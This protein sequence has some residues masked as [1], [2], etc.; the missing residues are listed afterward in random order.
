MKHIYKLI[1]VV[2]MLITSVASAQVITIKE[3]RT[4]AIGTNVT[5]RGIIING[6]EIGGSR[7]ITDGTA[8]LGI[9]ASAYPNLKRG[10]SIE[11]MGDLQHFSNLLQISANV[12]ITVLDSN[13][14]VPAPIDFTVSSAA[15][16]EQYEGQLVKINNVSSFQVIS[17]NTCGSA[18]STFDGN[19][20]YCLSNNSATPMRVSNPTGSAGDIIGKS[21]P[22]GKVSVV[23]I[24]SQF[25]AGAY[26]TTAT[27][28][29]Q[30][31]VRLY[32]DFILPPKPNIIS[33]PRPAMN[34]KINKPEITT[35]SIKVIF[36]TQNTG[37][38]KIEYG[39]TSALGSALGDSIFTTD[40]QVE[41]ANLTP[42]TIY[43]IKAV[44]A[45][46]FGVSSSKI[47][48]MVT[49]SLSSGV[50][51]VYFNNPVDTTAMAINK[52]I[53]LDKTM[54]D[55]VVA[56]INKAKKTLD[57]AIYN[58]NPSGSADFIAALNNAYSRG[59][60]VRIVYDGS[61]ANVG[62]NN[63]DPNIGII[64]RPSG[65]G[66]MH[67]KFMA[68][69]AF[70]SNPMTPWVWGGSTN[71][72][73]AQLQTDQNNMLFIQDQSLAKVYTLEFEEMF[74]SS[75]AKPDGTKNKLG[76]LK[77]DNTPHDLIIGGKYIE[78]YFSPSDRTTSRIVAACNSAD[79]D[80]YIMSM[81]FTRTDIAN[82]IRNRVL[83]GVYGG[84]I[85]DDT[86]GPGGTVFNTL[87]AA[88]VMDK[89]MLKYTGSGIMHHKVAIVDPNSFGSDPLVV[90]GSHNW[91]NGAENDNDENTLII[92]DADI[93]NQFYQ[94]Y[95]GLNSRN[96]GEALKGFA[97]FMIDSSLGGCLYKIIDVSTF[98]TKN[99]KWYINGVKEQTAAASFQVLKNSSAFDIALA[100]ANDT[101]SDSTS[102]VWILNSCTGIANPINN[103]S[104]NIFPNPTDGLVTI[105]LNGYG[106]GQLS[107]YDIHGKIQLTH[108]MN[109]VSQ[110]LD[111]SHL[112]SGLYIFKY[113]T[114]K[115]IYIQK[116]IVK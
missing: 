29:F 109:G 88:N 86:A 44:S 41:L 40:H 12:T 97:N 45:N 30:L 78:Q 101:A 47:V 82:A 26:D 71:L 19:K 39:T 70:D 13:K 72:T 113:D 9:F 28:G 100:V 90:T 75:G 24:I 18:V 17:S 36:K 107:V 62:L 20:N 59:V 116:V 4:K 96:A 60:L 83:V 91:S 108:R 84:C 50:I 68:I 73:K 27:T 114:G 98:A 80:I 38:T 34:T 64:S 81:S 32:E 2:A 112:A 37:S 52:A 10:D 106:Q 93:T 22:S 42:A 76:A 3:A 94:A 5:V 110:V 69:D 16:A 92:H 115:E 21:A 85:V 66:I 105:D 49:Q 53:Y 111:V 7:F 104:F 54:D 6:A 33:V 61:T 25:K 79:K 103:S 87:A 35:T 15:F 11:I 65:A 51:K 77:S 74:G 95:R 46:S 55:T 63:L 67:N 8:G 14:P 43:Y 48:T 56:Y 99:R 23:G 58:V 31:L 1:F 89:R 102:Q 57:M